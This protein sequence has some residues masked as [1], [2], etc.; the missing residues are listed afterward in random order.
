[1]PQVQEFYRKDIDGLRAVAIVP[2]VA[3]HAGVPGVTGGFVGVDVFFVLSGFLITSLLVAEI[4]RSGTVRLR[5][6]YARRIRRLFPALIVVVV[7][8]SLLGFVVLLP[9]FGQQDDL[10]WSA[11]ATALYSSNFHFWLNSP[12]YFDESADLK[13]LLH[14]WSLAVEEHFY[15]VWPP[16]LLALALLARRRP[17]SFDRLALAS[18]LAIL[19]VSASWCISSTRTT[20]V[21]AFYL[22]PSR[23]WEL[24]TGALLAIGLPRI[25]Q[26]RSASGGLCSL[27]G[28]A[29]IAAAVA[30]FDETLPFP[31]SL[32][33]LPVLGTALVVVGGHLCPGNVVQ[34]LLETKPLVLI[35]LLSYSWYL[36]HWPLLALVRAYL[37]EANLPRDLAIAVLS[38]ALAYASYR[39]IE[40]PIRFGRPGPFRR[41]ETTIAAGLACSIAACVP[42]VALLA[43]QAFGDHSSYDALVAARSDRPPLRAKCNQS[44]PFVALSPA[45]DCTSGD[46]GRSPMLLLWGDSHADH[47]S[48]LLEVFAATSPTAPTILARS[49][50]RCP[51]VPDYPTRDERRRR[52]CNAFNAAVLA[53]I[54]AL[55]DSGLRGVVLSGRWLRV[56]RAPR[57]AEIESSKGEPV[58]RAPDVAGSLAATVAELSTLGLNVLI[59]APMPEMRYDVP[60]CL[61]R[62]DADR[63]E[64]DRA[65][66]ERQRH[67]VMTL[68]HAIAAGRPNVRIFD[69]LGALCDA[70][71]CFVERD[72]SPLFVDDDHLTA[73]A[74][75]SLLPAARES[76]TWASAH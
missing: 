53:E 28:L 22:L 9:V 60:S 71:S 25:A 58:L 17:G 11:I 8:T 38:L 5:A 3:Y 49:F 76:L 26:Q 70:D 16:M 42:A 62:R 2:V 29:C 1:M 72:G 68:L 55:T 6:F 52:A 24:A 43:W 35:G 18:T 12:G 45:R 67:A 33:L 51:P 13:P 54:R 69:P 31:G 23:A 14:T 32:A 20:P 75:R 61:A 59:I 64:V 74:S 36:W 30:V 57:L 40:N 4:S 48:P 50:V 46:R 7:T 34:R 63:C 73:T 19:I 39:F 37:L 10:A 21:S 66:V 15:L 65:M 56:F 44:P 27:L 47:L 41:D